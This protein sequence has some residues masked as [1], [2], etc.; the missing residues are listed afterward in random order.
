ME[1]TPEPPDLDGFEYQET[2]G[3]G[4]FA[5]V[6]RYRQRFPRRSVAIKVLR[7]TTMDR[8]SR[9]QFIAEAN[10]MAQLSN[11]PAIAT[12]Y[13]AGVTDDARPYLVM[14][15][16]SRG[17]LASTYRLNPL[18]VDQALR[19]GLRIASALESAHRLGIVHR[20]VKP[21]NILITDY[22][23]AVLSDFGISTGDAQLAEATILH[24]ERTN[25]STL[26]GESTTLG[27]SVPWAPPEALDD[28]PMIDAR[29]DVYSL[30]ATLFT[31]LEGR[32]PFES[33]GGSNGVLHLSRRIERGA[34][35]PGERVDRTPELSALLRRAMSVD[36]VDRPQT[37][38]A[39]AEQLGATERSLGHEP[40]AIELLG[41][42]LRPVAAEGNDEATVRRDAT[43][44]PAEADQETRLR[45]TAVPGTGHRR[46]IASIAAGALLAIGSAT[47]FTFTSSGTANLETERTLSPTP[48]S[49]FTPTPTATLAPTIADVLDGLQMCDNP[50]YLEAMEEFK[51]EGGNESTPE[52]K[53]ISAI[54]EPAVLDLNLT[55]FCGEEVTDVNDSAS[56]WL[57]F[58]GDR[59]DVIALRDHLDAAYPCREIFP[60]IG[61][62]GGLDCA[63]G[64]HYIWL[65]TD[66]LFAKEL[67][68]GA[69][70]ISVSLDAFEWCE[71]N[72][73]NCWT[74]E[75][76]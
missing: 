40:T 34:L 16:C 27:L 71:E 52:K 61:P 54:W 24:T 39:F 62:D 19:I 64:N 51:A 53:P 76:W 57:V 69:P 46:L 12:I 66:P 17:S 11:H 20:D 7:A 73:F 65:E 32:S 55:P 10:T 9:H 15:Y 47:A 6:Y 26:S 48:P 60:E 41:D 29:S 25:I 31:L 18:P 38:L 21:A 37:A 5:D 50:D 43:A 67:G 2:L 63:S 3:S 58:Y 42:G 30:A 49:A 56:Q 36:P 23:A 72:E 4:G 68:A 28:D 1:T 75:P 44:S 13:S 59:N 22:G 70:V 74:P 8:V 14:E 35:V 33:P 45:G